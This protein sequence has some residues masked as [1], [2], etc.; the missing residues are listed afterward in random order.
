MDTG[1]P[2]LHGFGTSR[3]LQAHVDCF[4]S[5][6]L[7]RGA[8][9]QALGGI[10]VVQSTRNPD[11]ARRVAALARGQGYPVHIRGLQ[12]GAVVDTQIHCNAVRQ[13]WTADADWPRIRQAM[14]EEVQVIVSNTAD[15]GYVLDARDHAGLIGQP[16]AVPASFP[17]KLLVLLHHR[18]Q[19][20]PERALTL[21]PCELIERNG[22]VL[23]QTVLTLAQDWQLP[24]AFAEWLQR[25]C[26]WV[27]SL[28]DRIVPQALEPVG[29]VAEPYAL[30]AI[31]TQPGMVLPCVHESIVLTDELDVYER[32]KLF[33]LNA[34]HTLMV[35]H[36]LRDREAGRAPAT[37][38]VREAME[39]PVRRAALED[40]WN[41]DVL[42][43]FEALGRGAQTHL[44]RDRVR[45]RFLNPFLEHPLADIARNHAAKRQRRLAPIVA[46]AERV[47]PHLPMAHLRAVLA[48]A[49]KEATA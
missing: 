17:A 2:I 15:Q 46:L 3:F 25:H 11:S 29:A 30:W 27:N 36:W 14:V 41:E 32:Q 4:V 33:V 24:A 22:D 16:H 48:R 20:V 26:V 40:F 21:Y 42:P 28:V 37:L 12:D 5:Q 7:A 45:E 1:T 35:E 38:T 10:A 31:E 44:Y 23:R 39:D 6:A 13:A 9:G 34:G 18:W 47:A 43:V 19:Q 8:E 49:D